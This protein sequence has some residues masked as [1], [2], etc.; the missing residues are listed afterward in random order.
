MPHVASAQR[1]R[2][3]APNLGL[4]ERDRGVSRRS[5]RCGGRLRPQRWN[6]RGSLFFLAVLVEGRAGH[7]LHREEPRGTF[8]AELVERNEVGMTQV[9]ELAELVLEPV[10]VDRVA[11][12]ER[13][14]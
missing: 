11:L 12:R 3:L 2:Q 10:D 9:R 7:E 13:L 14:E 1:E 5:P 8:V 4:A 6:A